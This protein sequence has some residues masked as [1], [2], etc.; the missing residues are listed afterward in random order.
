VGTVLKTALGSLV[1]GRV[2]ALTFP[3]LSAPVWPAIRFTV[4][5]DTPFADQCGSEDE[6]TD[7]IRVQLDV[8]ALA[9]DDMKTLKSAVIAAMANTTPGAERVGGFETFDDDTKTNRAVIE[10]VFHPSS[11]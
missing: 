4:V 6:E 10:Y 3:Q 5:A 7:D 9:Y 8:V 2:H 11:I 1:D